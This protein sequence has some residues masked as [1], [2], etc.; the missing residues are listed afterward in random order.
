MYLGTNQVVLLLYSFL[1][2]YRI[3][4]HGQPLLLVPQGCLLLPQHQLV[5]L[6]LH[7]DLLQG[8]RQKIMVLREAVRHLHEQRPFVLSVLVKAAEHFVQLASLLSEFA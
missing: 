2:S 7:L 1:L 6:V 3:R 8:L 5:F 4:V